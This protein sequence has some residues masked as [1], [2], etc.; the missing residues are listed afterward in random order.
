MKPIAFY[1]PLKTPNHPT[2]SGDRQIARNVMSALT[3][4]FNTPVVLASE[5][6]SFEPTGNKD[7]QQRLLEQAQAECRRIPNDLGKASLWVTYHNYYK[8]PDLIGPHV[9][10]ALEIPYVQIEASRAKSRLTGPWAQFA[11]AAHDASDAADVIFHVTNED[12]IALERDRFGDQRLVE[13]PPFLDRDTLPEPSPCS[14][15]ILAVGM[16]RTGDKLTSYQLIADTLRLLKSSNWRLRIAGDGD[17]RAEVE[18]LFDPFG[19]KVEF[20]G[21]LTAEELARAYATSSL[22]LWPGVNEAFGMVYLEAQA[23]GLP[24]IA[25]YRPGVRDVLAPGSYPAIEDGPQGLAAAVDELLSDDDLRIQQ[26]RAAQTYVQSRHL[27]SAAISIF[28]DT[29]KPLLD[30]AT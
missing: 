29:L 16:M 11:K 21:A 6:R 15:P 17:A 2:P 20:L 14:G 24:V 28:Q 22:L 12:L 5:L 13:L 19:D 9:S 27:R 4:A 1:A 8:A 10:K 25:Q 30:E 23:A 7:A 3:N 18:T 26:G